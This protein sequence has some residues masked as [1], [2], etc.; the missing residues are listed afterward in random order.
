VQRTNESAI[1]KKLL[2]DDAVNAYNVCIVAEVLGAFEQAV[3]LAVGRPG[4]TSDEQ[5]YG[6][7]ILKEVQ[8]RLDR[9]VV[10]GAVYSTL[11]RLE[12]KGLIESRLGDSTEVRAGRPRRYYSIQP[13][14]VRAL[15]EAKAAADRMWAGVRWPIK[16]TT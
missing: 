12:S 16:G 7:E 9:D 5:A 6:R 10:A 15:N 2:T 8:R 4:K 1:N 3:L 13:A 11:E 14:G